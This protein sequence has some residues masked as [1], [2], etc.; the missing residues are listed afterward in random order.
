MI[1]RPVLT[2]LKELQERG[3]RAD[4]RL[5]EIDAEIAK[6]TDQ[7]LVLTRLKS[8][9]YMDSDLYLSQVDEINARARELR[10]LRRGIM[11]KTGED[12][13]IRKTEEML[14]YLECGDGQLEELDPLIFTVLIERLFLTADGNVKIRLRNGLEVK[15]SLA[16]EVR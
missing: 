14:E 10:R 9:G 11:E 2:Q 15:E 7:N 8:K 4:Q 13:Q 5:G 16:T 12:E 6:L 3:V 1:L